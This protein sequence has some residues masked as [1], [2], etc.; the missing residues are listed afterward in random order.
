[1]AQRDDLL[2]RS[3]LRI[4]LTCGGIAFSWRISRDFEETSFQ[5]LVD[6]DIYL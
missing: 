1:M 4:L 2:P 5:K 6:I 3:L